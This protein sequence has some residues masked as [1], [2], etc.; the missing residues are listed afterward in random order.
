MVAFAD[1]KHLFKHIYM[2][3]Q[4]VQGNSS[5]YT[6][7]NPIIPPSAAKVTITLTT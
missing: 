6:M 2:G 7:E 3:A 4:I 5:D 1:G